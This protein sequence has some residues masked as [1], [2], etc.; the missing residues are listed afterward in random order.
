MTT[1]FM[2]DTNILDKIKDEDFI[3]PNNLEGVSFCLTHIQETEIKAIPEK[4]KRDELLNITS[5]II[6]EP[7]SLLVWGQGNWGDK[8]G[9]DS[10]HEYYEQIKLEQTKLDEK[11]IN[12]KKKKTSVNIINDARIGATCLAENFV[13]VTED[14]DLRRIIKEINPKLIVL[15]FKEF[16]QELNTVMANT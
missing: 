16:K 3:L 7:V 14:K 8:F 6:E 1:T 9:T 12:P 15:N 4:E 5:K 2:F 10:T 13:L 11:K